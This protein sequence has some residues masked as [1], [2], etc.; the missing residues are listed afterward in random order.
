MGERPLILRPL[1][2]PPPPTPRCAHFASRGACKHGERCKF[3]HDVQGPPAN[4][5]AQPPPIRR[6]LQDATGTPA[7]PQD[8][9]GRERGRL[10]NYSGPPPFFWLYKMPRDAT[11]YRLLSDTL[12]AHG[13]RRAETDAER[14]HAVL[15]WSGSAK[16]PSPIPPLCA[17]NRL[18]LGTGGGTWLTRT[19]WHPRC[20]KAGRVPWPR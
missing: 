18:G 6:T 15:L 14:Q 12:A 1:P 11:E 17:V 3:A 8:T 7:N 4:P 10:H 9:A 20:G 16:A 5:Q 2:L 19:G 13:F